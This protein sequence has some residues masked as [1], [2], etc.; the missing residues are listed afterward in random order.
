MSSCHRG[1]ASRPPAPRS[2]DCPTGQ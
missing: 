2:K 1:R